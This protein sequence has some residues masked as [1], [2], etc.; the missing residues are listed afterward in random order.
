MLPQSILGSRDAGPVRAK[1][2]RLAEPIWSWW[3]PRFHFDAAVF[4]CAVVF[5][6][7]PGTG[8]AGGGDREPVWTG[9]VTSAMGVPDVPALDVAGCVGDH[10]ALT[11]NFRDEYYGLIPA[12]G[13]HVTGP[14]LVTS[15]AIDPDRCRWGERPVTFN[16]RRFQ[17]PR[18]DVS[19][20]DERMR[21]WARRLAVPK[22]LI[23]NQTRV[24][25][26]VVDRRGTMLP[27]VPVLTARPIDAGDAALSAAGGGAVVAA[28]FGV[29]VARR[30][31]HR[32]V[33]AHRAP[34]PG[35]RR[36]GAVAGAA[37]SARRSRPTTAGDLAA[38][39]V[40]VHH[41]YGIG[42][43]DGDRLLAWWTAWLPREPGGVNARRSPIGAA[44]R[45]QRT[46]VGEVALVVAVVGTAVLVP[47][48][49]A[50]AD[51]AEPTDFATE[52]VGIEP[53][54]PTIDVGVVGGDSFVELTAEP[55]T[56]VDRA[57][58][59]GR[60]VPAVQQRRHRRGEPTVADASPRTRAATAGRRR[61]VRP[62]AD[63]ESQWAQ[64][65]TRRQLRLARPPR[66]LDEPPAA[67][68]RA[69]RPRCSPG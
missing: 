31:R 51:P 50:H 46:A 61:R 60:A 38:S 21:R 8:A 48:G 10:A 30:C 14:W 62:T 40:A 32:A 13:D 1:V 58:L 39:A 6:R 20:L 37:R 33:G 3:S 43:S 69:R 44:C 4:V 45:G 24:V 27:A 17:R 47:A 2:E 57:R 19:R 36:R 35:A 15:G 68:R 56:E 63:G 11:A 34:A 25:E 22:L 66:P 42:E 55:G 65:A 7:R 12:V 49:V 54:T 18:V 26:C 23:A 9:V 64:V 16:R 52:I 28:R 53:A 67:G 59:L 41:A 5:R 29:A